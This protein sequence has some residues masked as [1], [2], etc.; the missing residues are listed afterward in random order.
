MPCWL[1]WG[2]AWGSFLA[3]MISAPRPERI[4]RN[5]Q[6]RSPAKSFAFSADAD[7]RRLFLA[8]ARRD[9]KEIS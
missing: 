2:C 6:T 5:D 3:A 8:S 1:R 9:P 4:L 7:S